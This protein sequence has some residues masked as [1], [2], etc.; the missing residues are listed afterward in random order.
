MSI[1]GKIATTSNDKTDTFQPFAHFKEC[2][3]LKVTQTLNAYAQQ[4]NIT[5]KFVD[6]SSTT[7]K[8]YEGDSERELK[9]VVVFGIFGRH[10]AV[11]FT[12][13]TQS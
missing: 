11:L 10:F 12:H 1:S 8:F 5:F 7:I 4:P 9:M 13:Q 2:S 6:L 3:H